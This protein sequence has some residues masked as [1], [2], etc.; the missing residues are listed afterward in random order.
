MNSV[1]YPY[2]ISKVLLFIIEGV[3]NC[4]GDAENPAVY[5]SCCNRKTR[6]DFLNDCRM[7]QIQPKM[8]L[9]ICLL[10]IYKNMP[11]VYA[12]FSALGQ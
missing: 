10:L 2:F 6:D 5:I 11:M 9:T 8:A 12:F 4:G 3:L 7:M 1:P